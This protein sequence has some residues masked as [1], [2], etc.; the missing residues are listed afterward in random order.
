MMLNLQNHCFD[1]SPDSVSISIHKKLTCVKSCS[2]NYSLI[3]WKNGNIDSI[4]T[5][6]HFCEPS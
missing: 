1:C 2:G 5:T 3:Y 6:S 4:C